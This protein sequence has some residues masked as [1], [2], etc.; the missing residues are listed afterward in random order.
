MQGTAKWDEH[1]CRTRRCCIEQSLIAHL[2]H[3]VD[4]EGGE[5]RPLRGCVDGQ[6]HLKCL[7]IPAVGHAWVQVDEGICP[8]G[9]RT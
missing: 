8:V 6:L 5:R 4:Q 3:C 7:R 9:I 1:Q 2:L